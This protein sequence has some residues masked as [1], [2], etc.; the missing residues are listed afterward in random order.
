MKEFHFT[1]TEELDGERIDKCLNML[2]DSLSRSYI[3]KLLASEAITVNAQT[4]KPSFRV[5][6]DDKIKLVLPP[7]ITPD[8]QPEK[9]PLSILYEDQIGRASCRERV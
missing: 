3:Q 5:S 2:I 1:V 7:S 6:V 8:I 9:I 4:V